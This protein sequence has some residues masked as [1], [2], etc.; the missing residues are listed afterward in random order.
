[1]H[2]IYYQSPAGNCGDDLNA[3]QWR[4][5]L[6]EACRADDDAVLLG[7]GS[8]FREDFLSEAA[9]RN[10]RV[11][12]LGSGAGTGPLPKLWPNDRW[13]ILAVRGPLTGQL[14]GRPETV[15]TDSAAL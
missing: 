2:V 7:I 3:E 8:I 13:S 12:V 10:K 6:P 14:I 9:T 15:A 5:L 4:A 11:F 1:M